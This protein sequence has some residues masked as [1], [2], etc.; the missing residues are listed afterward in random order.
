MSHTSYKAFAQTTPN[1]RERLGALKREYSTRTDLAT[2]AHIF[3]VVSLQRL[4]DMTYE[5][6]RHSKCS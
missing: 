5:L 3:G 6:D 1:P 2:L 4:S